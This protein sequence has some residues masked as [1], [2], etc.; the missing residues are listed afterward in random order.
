MKYMKYEM[1]YEFVLFSCFC[2]DSV[3]LT[4]IRVLIRVKHMSSWKKTTKCTAKSTQTAL[5]RTK[6][7]KRIR[8]LNTV[9]S[10]EQEAIIKSIQTKGNPN[11]FIE[12]TND[13]IR[14]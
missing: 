6:V 7:R 1:K 14:K 12:L 8:P 10:T 4:A 2:F 5:I 9:Y 3:Q 13:H 11:R